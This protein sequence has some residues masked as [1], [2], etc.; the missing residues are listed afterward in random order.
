MKKLFSVVAVLTLFFAGTTAFAETANLGFTVGSAYVLDQETFAFD[1]AITGAY[2]VNKFLAVGVQGGFDWIKKDASSGDSL[3]Y[4]DKDDFTA[5]ETIS[6]YIYTIPVLAVANLYI[7]VSNGFDEM[8]KFYVNLGAGYGWSIYKSNQD[9]PEGQDPEDVFSGLVYQGF[10]G[11]II[12]L[13][14]GA[15]NMDVLIE[16]GYRGTD[17]RRT[18]SGKEY[19]LKM[20]SAVARAGLLFRL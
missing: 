8:F 6:Q 5:G 11:A 13:G 20:G 15:E 17:F 9:I 14:A 16:A 7:P 2:S 1:S 4:G 12:P 3:A 19:E 18:I 10:V